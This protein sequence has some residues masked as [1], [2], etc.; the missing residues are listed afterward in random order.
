[1][2]EPF[3]E[4][5]GQ[6]SALA[7]AFGLRA[8]ELHDFSASI[9]PHPPSQAVV[10]ALSAAVTGRTALATYPEMHY[11]A[12]KEAVALYADVSAASIIVDGGVMQ[13]LADTLEV[14]RPRRCLVPYPCFAEYA[15]MLAACAVE[16]APHALDAA[17]GFALE[18]DH[19]IAAM[20]AASADA[21]LV[22]NPQSPCGRLATADELLRLYEA[23][24]ALGAT[25]IVDEAFI[26]YAPEQSL[27]SRAAVLPGLVVL[28]SL[29]K[30]FA[31]PGLRVAY[32]V[33]EPA[34]RAAIEAVI[35][36][37]PVGALAAE[38]ARLVVGERASIAATRQMNAE[39]REW[40][41]AELK[42]LG[43]GVYSAAANYIMVR[44]GEQLDGR[45]IWQR[46]IVEHRVVVRAC[47]NFEGLDENFFRVGIRTRAE[48]Q[49]LVEA[50]A[51]VLR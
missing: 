42:K 7:A 31:M 19:L 16:R 12:L 18:P 20:K 47:A 9:H 37:W 23:V 45:R 27:A 48:N 43:L 51:A 46:L 50:F 24:H 25:L 29:T 5:G 14:L 28:R 36:S 26:D 32:A 4:H 40:L 3:P 44:V 49:I 38:A 30:F 2:S 17:E 1:M 8:E 34:L 39:E 15:K 6:M 21:L 10:T 33:A 11:T 41:V 22:A 35:P 13:L